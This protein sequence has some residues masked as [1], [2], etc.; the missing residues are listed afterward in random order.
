MKTP[1]QVR[2]FRYFVESMKK[3][4]KILQASPSFDSILSDNHFSELWQ[5]YFIGYNHV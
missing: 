5:L 1:F 4:I 3:N 2:L